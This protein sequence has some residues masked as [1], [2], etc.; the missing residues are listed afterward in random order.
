MAK[1]TNNEQRIPIRRTMATKI[2]VIILLSVA[3]AMVLIDVIVVPKINT[4]ATEICNL[5]QQTQGAVSNIDHIVG[6]VVVAVNKM[7]DCLSE[8]TAFL[9]ENV[10]SDY[11]KFGQ[12]SVQ[13]HDDAEYGYG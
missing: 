6:D 11:E 13:Y 2:G 3:L 8:T 7:A 9:Q 1:K 12:V 5:A 4:L 10:V